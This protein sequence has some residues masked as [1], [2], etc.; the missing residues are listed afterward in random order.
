MIIFVVS[1]ISDLKADLIFVSV[2]VSTAEVESSRI[3][4]F[5]FLSKA[6]AI[7]KRCFCPPDTLFPPCSI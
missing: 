7:H 3:N 4:I 1:G 2:A 5:G 6:L